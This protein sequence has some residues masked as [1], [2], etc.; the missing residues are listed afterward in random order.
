MSYE[1]HW[2]SEIYGE[3]VAHLELRSLDP[4]EATLPVNETGYRSH[5]LSAS[6]VLDRG[7]P[8]AVR[9]DLA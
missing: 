4:E 5:F 2:L 9:A 6:E 3:P 8:V 1:P 7:G